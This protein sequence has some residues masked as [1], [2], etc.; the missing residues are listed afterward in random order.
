VDRH[1][2]YLARTDQGIL[3]V[4]KRKNKQKKKPDEAYLL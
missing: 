3:Q 2:K 4:K 1:K